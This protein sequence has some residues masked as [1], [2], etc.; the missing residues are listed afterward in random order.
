[1]SIPQAH[2][3]IAVRDYQYE[4]TDG[5][6]RAYEG[7]KAM[8]EKLAKAMG[9]RMVYLDVRNRRVIGT[10]RGGWRVLSDCEDPM[11]LWTYAWSRLHCEHIVMPWWHRW[12]I[13]F[14]ERLA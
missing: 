13:S 1:M 7:H 9:Y 12:W 2:I 6:V 8:C 10:F 11:N 5:I 4:I 14:W 3:D